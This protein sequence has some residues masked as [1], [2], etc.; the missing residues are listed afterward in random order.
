MLRPHSLWSILD[1]PDV[2]MF[3]LSAGKVLDLYYLRTGERV[4][5]MSSPSS[6]AFTQIHMINFPWELLL[7]TGQ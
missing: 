2:N 1:D 6:M 7:L 4:W 3:V 5:R